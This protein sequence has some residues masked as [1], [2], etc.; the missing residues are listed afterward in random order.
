MTWRTVSL[1]RLYRRHEQRGYEDLPLLSVYRD[2]GVVPRG[3]RDDNFNRPGEDLSSYKLVEVADLVLNKMKT[4]QG[5]LGV[6]A[7]RGIVS[8][9]YFVAQRIADVEDRFMHHL[10]RSQPL[11]AEYGARS[12]G[13]RPS[14]WDLPWDEFASIKVRLPPSAEQRAIA[15]FLDTETARIDALITSKQHL[16]DL[17]HERA[18][19]VLETVV[20]RPGHPEINLHRLVRRFVDYR[21]ATPA[22]SDEGIPLATAGHVKDGELDLSTDPQFVSEEIY[23]DWMRRGFPEC[24]DVLMTM[25]APLGE[26]AEVDQLP[27]A[28]AQ[29]VV[30]MKPNE[31]FVSGAFLAL[32]LRTPAFQARLAGSATGSTALGIRADRLKSL[33]MPVPPRSF[34]AE[35]VAEARAAFAKARCLRRLLVEQVALLKEHRQALITAAVTGELEIPGVAA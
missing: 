24:G 10:L 28:L 6:S 9:A 17:S 13:I 20:W 15:D 29:R 4:W 31:R 12:K 18:A 5:S 7:H 26:V 23:E 16:M 19:A 21:G 35:A 32:L 30:L 8:P 3:G 34:Q 14:Q 25:E 22:K 33:T 2:H 1:N 27:I 11:I